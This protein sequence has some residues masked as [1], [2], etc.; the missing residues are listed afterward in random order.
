M[1]QYSSLFIRLRGLLL[2]NSLVKQVDEGSKGGSLQ[3]LG[4][5][6]GEKWF[7]CRIPCITKGFASLE[8]DLVILRLGLDSIEVCFGN[9]VR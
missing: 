4:A 2:N 8:I 3:H 9:G 1:L 6:V 7:P 5:D